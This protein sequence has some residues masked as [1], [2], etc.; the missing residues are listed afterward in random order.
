MAL[1]FWR[2]K[3]GEPTADSDSPSGF[4]P[5]GEKDAAKGSPDA[6]DVENPGGRR[7]SRIDRPIADP[8]IGGGDDTD[9]SLSVGKQMELEAGNAIKYR[10]CSWQKVRHRQHLQFSNLGNQY[11]RHTLQR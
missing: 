11:S 3:A 9:S 1:K 6:Y 10:S 8:I 5:A 2:N 4:T 7:M